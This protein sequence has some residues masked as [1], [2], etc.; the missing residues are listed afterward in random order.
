MVLVVS[1][2]PDQLL[3]AFGAFLM[4]CSAIVVSAGASKPPQT[5]INVLAITKRNGNICDIDIHA[6]TKL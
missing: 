2:R 3:I 6:Q 4:D 5:D 1:V